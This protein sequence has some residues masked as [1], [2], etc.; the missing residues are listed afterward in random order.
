MREGEREG[1]SE[2]GREGGTEGGR[3]GGREGL[4][5]FSVRTFCLTVPRNFVEEPVCVR[6]KIW[7]REKLATREGAS[8]T[9]F[10]QIVLSHSTE[11]SRRGILLCFKKSQVSKKS[12][13][14]KGIS[15]FSME[16]LLSHCNDKLRRGT[17]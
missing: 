13:S 15:R 3:E 8:I 6:K 16:N 12:M 17:R 9:I 7:Y 10:P 4:S 14:K 11:S 1:G 5:R 2:G